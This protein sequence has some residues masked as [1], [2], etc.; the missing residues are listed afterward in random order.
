MKI[1]C[2]EKNLDLLYTSDTEVY[3]FH[4]A[5]YLGLLSQCTP[6]PYF[7][8]VSKDKGFDGLIEYMKRKEFFVERVLSIED[9]LFVKRTKEIKEDPV[10]VIKKRI[11]SQAKPAKLK[12]LRNAIK[13]WL[14]EDA[15][16]EEILDSLK[17]DFLTIDEKGKVIYS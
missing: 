11:L 16:V 9:I 12:T 17:K 10:A 5:Y 7:H 2:L 6:K 1:A 8:I 13:T 15:A 3:D 14:G 4:I